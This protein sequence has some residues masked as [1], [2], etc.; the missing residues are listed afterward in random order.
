MKS[1]ILHGN[2]FDILPTLPDNF[3]DLI[4]TDPP[5]MT[6]DLFFDKAGFDVDAWLQLCLRV[7]KPD[8]YLISF[9]SFELLAKISTV[10]NTRWAGV[11]L[12]PQGT[13][14]TANAKK[15]M[16]K[17]EFYSVFAHPEHK[18]G[19]LVFNKLMIPGEPYIKKQNYTGYLR[20]G[21]DS[22]SRAS[23]SAWTKQ[24][25]VQNNEGWRYH[26]NVIEAPNKPLMKHNER[27]EHP[28][29]KPVSL[30]KP[31]IEFTTNENMIVLDPFAGSGTTA[32]A[33]LETKRNY[34]CIEQ[35]PEYYQMMCDRVDT[36][37]KENPS[38][39][40]ELLYENQG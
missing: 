13:M 7:C 14:R 33:C 8:G 10:F 32:I 24:G 28:S 38:E 23:T 6:T 35:H 37:H 19:N 9:G 27:T 22:L 5:Y 11:W 36:W 17:S 25:Y 16:S 18:V 29:Q 21:K 26:T 40:L 15:P 4:L 2:C 34:I 30:F 3:A 20:D 12:K 1:Q 31:L 39:Q